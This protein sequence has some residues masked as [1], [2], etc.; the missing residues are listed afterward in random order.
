[1]AGLNIVALS[2]ALT[3]LGAGPNPNSLEETSALTRAL[4]TA[5]A[6]MAVADASARAEADARAHTFLGPLGLTWLREGLTGEHGVDE[7]ALTLSQVFEVSGRASLRADAA[8]A[9]GLRAKHEAEA[10]RLRYIALVRLCFHR[11]RVAQERSSVFRLWR[12]EL[13]ETTRQLEERVKGGAEPGWASRHGHHELTHATLELKRSEAERDALMAKL[14]VLTGWERP[15]QPPSL[16]APDLP[17]LEQGGVA[18]YLT[19]LERHPSALAIAAQQTRAS[20]LTE[21]GERAWVPDLELNAGFKRA[22]NAHSESQ[23]YVAGAKLSIPLGGEAHA[24][25]ARGRA[26]QRRAQ[27]ELYAWRLR[28]SAQLREAYV[29]AERIIEAA[30]LAQLH[31]ED[32]H[33]L[34]L[35]SAHAAYKGGELDL[36]GLLEAHSDARDDRLQAL[37]LSEEAWKAVIR[38]DLVSGGKP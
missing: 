5:N 8:R 10:N 32:G 29:R 9:S 22:G 16:S 12:T 33:E 17:S 25:G 34:L 18:T 23:G 37:S 24:E 15:E 28:Q 27:R 31:L 14:M 3:L 1:M 30:R 11:V 6:T 36:D 4:R 38:L 7:D 20:L 26:E 2:L 35:R 13:L 21:A 19:R